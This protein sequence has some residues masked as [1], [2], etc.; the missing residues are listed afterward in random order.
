MKSWK[1]E[2]SG[3]N[4][5]DGIKCSCLKVGLNLCPRLKISPGEW[6]DGKMTRVLHPAQSAFP[7]K[8][9]GHKMKPQAIDDWFI[10]AP[11]FAG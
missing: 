11:D 6:A 2:G 3:W 10:T 1:S 9:A 8:L 7:F 4:S 5:P